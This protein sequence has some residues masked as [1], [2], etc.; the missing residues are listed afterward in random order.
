MTERRGVPCCSRRAFVA[1]AAL[2]PACAWLVEGCGGGEREGDD[3]P[4]GPA[5]GSALPPGVTRDGATLLVRVA[6]VPQLAQVGGAV[7]LPGP[8]VIVTRPGAADY[9]A[10]SAD[11]PHAGSFV[12]GREGAL[13]VCPAHGSAFDLTGGR[14]RGPADVGLAALA[15]TFD[16]RGG[17]LHVT[18]P[19]ARG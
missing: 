6:A 3:G 16:A 4:I 19:A 12:G 14:V 1:R 7:A 8:R 5:P 2:L 15:A 13:L 10:L 9:R 18:L 17:T 11:C